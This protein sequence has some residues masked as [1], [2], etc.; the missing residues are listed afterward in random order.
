M[1]HSC[2]HDSVLQFANGMVCA[3]TGVRCCVADERLECFDWLRNCLV[4]ISK[5]SASRRFLLTERLTAF[6]TYLF[7]DLLT[8]LFADLLTCLFADLLRSLFTDLQIYILIY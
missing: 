2:E 4:L 6:L 7:T 5:D 1:L 8:C 3:V